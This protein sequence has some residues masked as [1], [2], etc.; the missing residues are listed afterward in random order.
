MHFATALDRTL[1]K[2]FGFLDEVSSMKLAD[3]KGSTDRFKVQTK[4]LPPPPPLPSSPMHR[5]RGTITGCLLSNNAVLRIIGRHDHNEC[6]TVSH[7]H[8]NQG[9]AD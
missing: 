5:H 1:S 3:R 2:V 7:V 4:Y 6:A 9:S 8:F